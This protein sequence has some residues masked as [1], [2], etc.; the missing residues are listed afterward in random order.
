MEQAIIIGGTQ[1]NTTTDERVD[2]YTDALKEAGIS[3]ESVQYAD[4][5]ADKA[6]SIW[7][8]YLLV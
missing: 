2:G 8:I 5:L 1:G 3:I 6:A 7:K 4:G